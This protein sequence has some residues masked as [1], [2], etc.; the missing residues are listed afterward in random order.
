MWSDTLVLAERALVLRI[1]VWGAFSALTGTILL[2]LTTIRPRA[3]ALLSHFAAQ[4][5]AWGLVEILGAVCW[6][7]LIPQRDLAGAE[8]LDD[9]LWFLAGLEAGMIGIGV[10]LLAAGWAL[11]RRLSL[12][13][14]GIA[15]LIHGLALLVLDLGAISRIA[16]IRIA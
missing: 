13:G 8:R 14:S 5:A 16:A 1:L 15:V 6:W 9:M 4:S 12:F 7:R 2:L 3:T 11:D 10:A